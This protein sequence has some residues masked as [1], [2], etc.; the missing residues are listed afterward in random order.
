MKQKPKPKAA[1]T[2]RRRR[3]EARL[4]Q[5]RKEPR[6]KVVGRTSVTN[7]Q[8]L[9]HELQVHQIELEKQNAELR[10]ARDTAE[11]LSEKYNDLYDFAPVGYCIVS[12]KGLILEANLTAAKLLGMARGSLTGHSLGRF[13]LPE[14]QD[15]YDH[16][17]QQVFQSLSAGAPQVCELRMVKEG[18]TIWWARLEGGYREGG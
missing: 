10:V 5:Q 9:L 12:E 1:T 4:R 14:D 8:R 18:K 2:E 11:E 6:A 7:T 16:H 13:I 3:A 15:I 17:R